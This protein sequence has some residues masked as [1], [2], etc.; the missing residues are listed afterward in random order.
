MDDRDFNE[1]AGR[2]EGV[3]R[4][5][6]H[7]TAALEDAGTIDGPCFADGLRS[8]VRP[9]ED[10]APHL[11]AAKQTLVELADALDD[12]RSSRQSR[13]SQD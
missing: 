8:A 4:L 1:L 3:A 2:I 13:G 6:L 11:T 9:S 5:V 7:L 10:A 12:A